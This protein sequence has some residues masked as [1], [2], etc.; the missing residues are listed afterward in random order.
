MRPLCVFDLDHTLV[1]SP[2]DL[3]ALKVELRALLAEAR[4]PLPPAADAW[5]IGDLIVRGAAGLAQDAALAARCWDLC[6]E[7]EHRA[8]RDVS[9]E[10]GALEALVELRAAGYPMAVWTNNTRPVAEAALR[11]CDLE[12]YFGL[13]VTRDEAPL[14][15]DPGGI[16][17]F[18]KAF[19][20]RRIL[21]IGDSWVDGAAARA[22]GARF[23]AY[24]TDPAELAR[25]GVAAEIRLTDLR[26]LPAALLGL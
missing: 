1:R 24:G 19:P 17:L 12:S 16:R 18:E 14:K 6:A 20:E 25:R 23:I 2:L 8:L 7:H 15:P 21:V 13:V 4:V 10:P 3:P 22:G 26:T 9:R 5:T 11:A